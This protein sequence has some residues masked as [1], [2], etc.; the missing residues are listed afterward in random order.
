MAKFKDNSN[1][2][3]M[4]ISVSFEEQIIPGT[5]EHAI[6][7]IVENH[8]DTSKLEERY[9]NDETGQKAYSPKTLIK[10]I[11]LSYSKG[12]FTSRR[13]EHACKTNIQFMAI[14]GN[15]MPDHSTIAAFVSSI[16][17]EVMDIF[18]S[19]LL[20]CGELDLIGGETFA[21]DGCK[22]SSNASKE[23]SGTFKELEKKKEKLKKVLQDMTK[24]H[25]ENDT[26][27]DD[28]FKKRKKKYKDKIAKINT[29]LEENEPKMGTRGKEIKS[30]ITDNESGKIKSGSGFIQ[31]YNGLAVADDKTQV[32]VSAEAF[33]TGQEGPQLETMIEQTDKN[34]KQAGIEN[35]LKEKKFLADTN[36]FSEENCKVLEEKEID[37]YIPDQHF[38]NRDPRFP[39]KYPR[40]KK[41]NLYSKED[42]N[43]NEKDNS[44]T[45][46]AGKTLQYEGTVTNHGNKGR[47]YLAKH[48]DCE[49]CHLKSKCLQKNSSRRSFSITDVPKPKTYSKKMK[50]KIDTPNGRHM[51]SKRMGIVEPVFANIT[52]HKRLAEFTLRGKAKVNIQWLLYCCVHN[53]GKMVGV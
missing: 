49:K 28:D 4:F 6:Y 3:G 14:S 27:S 11:L 9:N 30:N 21:I 19:I 34:L 41:K 39:D 36:Y 7:D 31:G 40:R 44:F 5:I 51:Y 43:Y 12:L 1:E 17:E 48:E 20:R 15:G 8:I 45:C 32:I 38:R 25:K 35:G 53:I 13:I 47:R 26:L 18:S 50:E 23:Y 10:I 46:P 22:L 42:F 52:V 29:F 2:Q 37:G 16:D 24:R 33:G